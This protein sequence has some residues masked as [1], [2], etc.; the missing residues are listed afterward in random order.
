[1]GLVTA[2]LTEVYSWR[3]RESCNAVEVNDVVAHR[4]AMTCSRTESL[5]RQRL[6]KG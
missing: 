4:L 6:A 1:M 2:E 5:C 3:W